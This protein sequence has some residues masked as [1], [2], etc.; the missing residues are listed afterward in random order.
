MH[1]LRVYSLLMLTLGAQAHADA[2]Q[3]AIIIAIRHA[4]LQSVAAAA[5]ADIR[6]YACHFHYAGC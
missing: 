6:T 4:I 5:A 3:R 2:A 1:T